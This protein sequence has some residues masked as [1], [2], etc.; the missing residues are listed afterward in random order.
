MA[1]QEEEAAVNTTPTQYHI[2]KGK[3]AL[4]IQIEKPTKAD[5][6]YKVGCLYLQAAPFKAEVNGNKTYDWEGKKIS[7]KFGINDLTQIN[8]ALKYGEGCE[9]FHSFGNSNKVIK[10]EPK[11]GGG[12][13]I[14]I[15]ET[16]KEAN[17]K[18]SISV[19]IS[20]EE[21][22]TLATLITFAI[23]LIHNWF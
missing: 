2:F 5:Q 7:V 13:F 6:K 4:R 1:E 15:T 20:A 19:P 22:S 17:T 21:T 8:H 11:E 23:P 16:V 12:Y 14:S 18:N 9:V 3:S 10:L